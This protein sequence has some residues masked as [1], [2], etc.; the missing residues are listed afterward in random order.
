MTTRPLTGALRTPSRRAASLFALT[1][2]SVAAGCARTPE[3]MYRTTVQGP[4]PV[5]RAPAAAFVPLVPVSQASSRCEVLG[6]PPPQ[7][8]HTVLSLVYGTPAERRINVSL[9]ADGKPLRYSDV[10]GDLI[11]N[12]G[13]DGD[14]TSISINLAQRQVVAMNRRAGEAQEAIM[15]PF[16]EAADAPNLDRPME[17]LHRVMVACRRGDQELRLRPGGA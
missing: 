16:D 5:R 12:D 14:M 6:N 9:D 7:L 1:L 2:L 13:H 11:I 8:G 4:M 15:I 3:P 10:R 17:T